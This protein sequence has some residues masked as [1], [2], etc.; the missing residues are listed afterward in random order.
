MFSCRGTNIPSILGVAFSSHDTEDV[1]DVE[2]VEDADDVEDDDDDDIEYVDDV[3]GVDVNKDNE[4]VDD[5]EYDNVC[6][7]R[8]AVVML[9]RARAPSTSISIALSCV[10]GLISNATN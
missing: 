10:F 6:L 1:E 3:E 4:E 7:D 9:S 2:D 8:V 5:N